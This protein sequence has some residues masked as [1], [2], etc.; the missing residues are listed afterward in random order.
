MINFICPKCGFDLSPGGCCDKNDSCSGWRPSIS[1][2]I[3]MREQFMK[4]ETENLRREES[5]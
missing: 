5:K 2:Q 1:D 3:L 4:E